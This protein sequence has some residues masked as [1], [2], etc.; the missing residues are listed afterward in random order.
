MNILAGIL[1]QPEKEKK[2][3]LRDD[4]DVDRLAAIKGIMRMARDG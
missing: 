4:L 2:N 3:Q 1:S